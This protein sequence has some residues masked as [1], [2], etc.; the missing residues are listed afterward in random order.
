[1]ARGHGRSVEVMSDLPPPVPPPPPPGDHTGSAPPPPPPPPPA[2]S[3]APAPGYAPQQ[4]Y[5]QPPPPGYGAPAVAPQMMSPWPQGPPTS[6]DR[7]WALLCH[8]S[9]F[10]FGL[11]GPL[12]VMVT[13]GNESRFIKDQAVETLNFHITVFIATIVS[14]VL[15]LVLIGFVMM[16]A[17]VIGSWVFGI[18]GAIAANKGEA[19]RYPINIRM[20]SP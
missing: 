10:V 4:G 13:K 17:V 7:T 18:I 11:F 6:D 19:Y 8:L 20:V 15:M 12:I 2:G 9:I 14:F 16:F 3:Q 1:M 5:Q